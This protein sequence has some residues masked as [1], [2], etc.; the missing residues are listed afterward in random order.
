LTQTLL[1]ERPW[2]R[3][4]VYPGLRPEPLV[5]SRVAPRETRYGRTELRRR[6]AEDL[7]ARLNGL[8]G[9]RMAAAGSAIPFAGGAFGSVFSIEGRPDP[10][11]QSGEWPWADVRIAISTDYLR[12]LGVPIFEGRTFGDADGRDAPPVALVSRSLANTYWGIHNTV[13]RR[14]RFPGANMHWVTIV[15]VVGDVKWT[16]L[17]EEKSPALY[18]PLAQADATV[19]GIILR[20]ETDPQQIA[21]N[22][23][24]I[25]SSLD[26]DTPIG[27]IRT[28]EALIVESVARPRFTA[29]LLA[30]FAAVAL[31]LGAIGVYGVLAYAVNRR[32][33][34]FGVR[35]ALG[36][37]ARDIVYTVL[38]EGARLTLSGLVLGLLGA[39]AA[40]R[41]LST[42]LFG[43]E[44]ANIGILASV[45]LLLFLI[46]LVASYLPARRAAMVDPVVALRAE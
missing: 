30:V 36:A 14:I 35:L 4:G 39:V 34:E 9:V 17:A 13:G 43:I 10:A 40:T 8:P 38:R 29:F 25:V 31:F 21:A 41:A 37:S 1:L 20:T 23:R 16:S 7:L 18:L 3:M 33:Q 12:V 2:T 26:K 6:L 11:T 15:G 32:T 24:G 22:L 42:L 28:S 27:D 19:I 44:P 45:A 5:S 46:G